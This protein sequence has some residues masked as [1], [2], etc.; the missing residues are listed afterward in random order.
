MKYGLVLDKVFAGHAPP[1][2]HPERPDRIRSLLQTIDRWG[3]AARLKRV[4]PVA[5]EEQWIRRIHSQSHLERIKQTEGRSL[6]LDV[7]TYASPDSFRIALLAIGA[8]LGLLDQLL[9][10][11]IGGGFALVRPPGHH[12]ETNKAMGFCLFNNIAI[13]AEFALK[14][15][16]LE[17]VA[18]VDFDVH[19]GNGTQQIFYSRSDVLYVS[20]HQ[21]PFYPG[22]GHFQEL[23]DGSGTGFTLNFPLPAGT[24]NQFYCSLF[25][26]FV[27]PVLS[28]Y[29]PD[30]ILVS[31]GYDGHRNDPLGGMDL[32]EN[33]FGELVNLLNRVAGEVCGGR[34]LY[35]LEGGY[36]LKALSQSVVRTIAT[37]LE[38][39][40]FGIEEKQL[41]QYAPYRDQMKV[42]FSRW[43]K[44]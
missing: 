23:G 11:T 14:A 33:G 24:G 22:S 37:T 8:V 34:I 32:D 36:D 39:E 41:S 26:D 28:L 17:K 9:E 12:A 29:Q 1:P 31:A 42:H 20:Q 5:V 15:H 6:Q 4:S 35:V 21:Y 3:K 16:G 10:G 30:L 19:H 13:A 25:R 18:I 27:V 40:T 43:W 7:D 44:L 2:G 38:P